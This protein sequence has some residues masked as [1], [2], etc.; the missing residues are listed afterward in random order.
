MLQGRKGKIEFYKLFENDEAFKASLMQSMRRIVNFKEN[1]C[2]I[3]L[4]N[5]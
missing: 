1:V 5:R 4:N 3:F 2:L